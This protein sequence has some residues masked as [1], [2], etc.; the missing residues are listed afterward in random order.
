MRWLIGLLLVLAVVAVA[1]DQ[2]VAAEVEQRAEARLAERLGTETDVELHGWPVGL[3]V[4][5]GQVPRLTAHAE[6]VRVEGGVR[7]ARLDAELTEVS[8][9]RSAARLPRA[10]TAEFTAVLTEQALR[11]ALGA[12]E[13]LVSLSLRDGI[14]VLDVA[15][16]QVEA[17]VVARDGA[18][19]VEPR[20]ALSALLGAGGLRVDLSD[21]PGAPAAREVEVQEGR[22]VVRGVLEGLVGP[23]GA[24]GE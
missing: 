22:L 19:V 10:A 7:I 11:D 4:L 16:L 9:D 5:L 21:Q 6:D 15:G 13:Q 3:R 12:P 18:V 14:A 1:A 20:D 17:D 8:F 23:E 24:G 2:V